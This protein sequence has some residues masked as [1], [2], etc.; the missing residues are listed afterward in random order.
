M[1]GVGSGE[2]D[3]G[4]LVLRSVIRHPALVAELLESLAK[5]RDVAVAEDPPNTRDEA[6][7][8][9]SRSTYCWARKRTMACPTVSRIVLTD[10]TSR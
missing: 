1:L 6:I 10:R 4:L 2:V 7:L 8:P 3:L 9:P 5:P